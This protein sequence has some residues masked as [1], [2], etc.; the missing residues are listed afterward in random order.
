MIGRNV[1]YYSLSNLLTSF[2]RGDKKKKKNTPNI[3][4]ASLKAHYRQEKGLLP[5]SPTRAALERNHSS[6]EA[7]FSTLEARG[8]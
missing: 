7:P 6:D 1:C 5:P 3:S 2:Y 4:V 8:D